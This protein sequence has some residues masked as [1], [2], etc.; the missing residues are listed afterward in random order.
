MLPSIVIDKDDTESKQ[1]EITALD[2]GHLVIGVQS[3]ELD[4]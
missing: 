4:M 3:A 2:V 1:V